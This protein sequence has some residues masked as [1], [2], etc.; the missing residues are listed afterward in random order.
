MLLA[1]SMHSGKSFLG[2]FWK[3]P[4][5]CLLVTVTS[6][7]WLTAQSVENESADD[8]FASKLNI[9]EAQWKRGFHGFNLICMGVDLDHQTLTRWRRIP[10]KDKVLVMMGNL[11]ANLLRRNPIDLDF[12][13]NNGGSVLIASD[14]PHTLFPEFFGAGVPVSRALGRR[15]IQF[16]TSAGVMAE[17]LEDS[18]AGQFHDCPVVTKIETPIPLLAGVDSL[19]TNRPGVIQVGAN[20]QWKGL[21]YLP[22]LHP[23]VN[24][25]VDSRFGNLF[26]IAGE[27]ASGGKLVCF[28]DHSMFTNQ[29]LMHGDN[30]R[31]AKQC[32]EWLSGEDRKK[33]LVLV[34]G[35]AQPEV[36]PADLNVELPQPTSEEVVDALKDLPP[37]AMLD[38]G[39]AVL[40]VVEE[41]NMINEFIN[42]QMDSFRPQ[43]IRRF[44]IFVMFAIACLFA[45]ITYTW[46]KKLRRRTISD[47]ANIKALENRKAAK[48]L[49]K[50]ESNQSKACFERQMAVLAM[51]DSFCLD[52]TNRRFEGLP[53]FPEGV[54]VGD[55]EH[56]VGIK[57]AMK[58]IGSDYRSQPRDFWNEKRLLAVEGAVAHW[59]AYFES[60]MSKTLIGS[61]QRSDLPL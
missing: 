38:F 60:G 49:K 17:K 9:S 10:A 58:M 36:N 34:D 22:P 31:A 28:A 52:F 27:N 12:Y 48:R 43:Q 41:E 15:G 32:L 7:S 56:G 53:S 8:R 47:I 4:V 54:S 29:M 24:R 57:S 3:L 35:V 50:L 30:A 14:S 5:L 1:N 23:V 46:Q 42:A 13:L 45:V 2:Y 16:V 55:D 26:S 11:N 18:F 39:N 37:S 20:T 33:V 21:A 25:L 61:S 6:A 44:W 19:V 59:R 40:G 51:L